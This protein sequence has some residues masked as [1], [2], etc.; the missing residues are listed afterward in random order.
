MQHKPVL[1]LVDMLP[2]GGPKKAPSSFT[3][4][5]LHL[6]IAFACR[7]ATTCM[8]Q[9]CYLCTDAA[10]VCVCVFLC[11]KWEMPA[12]LSKAEEQFLGKASKR[13]RIR[14]WHYASK[15]E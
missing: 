13:S 11:Y 12:S 5:L 4:L 10:I 1:D 9:C 8:P 14:S 15:T 6:A 3:S 2:H 7:D